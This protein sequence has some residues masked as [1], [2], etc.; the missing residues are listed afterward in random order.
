MGGRQSILGVACSVGW[1]VGLGWAARA[2]SGAP[3]ACVSYARARKGKTICYHVDRPSGPDQSPPPFS[4]V[5][6]SLAFLA[7]SLS[8]WSDFCSLCCSFVS[9]LALA[10]APSQA[11]HI[12]KQVSVSGRRT[13]RHNPANHHYHCWPIDD[14]G[15][16]CCCRLGW[17]SSIQPLR[18]L[19]RRASSWRCS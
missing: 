11:H 16:C 9:L 12:S 19:G 6:P 15:N 7:L 2:P 1:P 3:R 13:H 8:P 14:N 18:S 10:A 4:L 5:S 17:C